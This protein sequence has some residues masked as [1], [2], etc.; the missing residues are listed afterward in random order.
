MNTGIMHHRCRAHL[1]RDRQPRPHRGA[2]PELH[3]VQRILPTR[4]DPGHLRREC[5]CPSANALACMCVRTRMCACVRA[6]VCVCLSLSLSLSVCVCVCVCV[7]CLCVWWGYLISRVASIALHAMRNL[8]P[9]YAC[10]GLWRR[11]I[12]RRVVN[13]ILDGE[14]SIAMMA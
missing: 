6:F 12:V 3:P 7:C 14:T 8:L 1:R 9:V 5:L 10:S 13:A 2:N 4:Q 11:H